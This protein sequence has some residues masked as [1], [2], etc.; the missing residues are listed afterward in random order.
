LFIVVER[1]VH[2]RLDI[3]DLNPVYAGVHIL[4]KKLYLKSKGSCGGAG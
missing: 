2:A 3:S 1:R 4:F